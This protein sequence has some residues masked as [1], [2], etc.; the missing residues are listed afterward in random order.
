MLSHPRLISDSHPHLCA[1]LTFSRSQEPVT[2]LTRV[3]LCIATMIQSSTTSSEYD[4]M[5]CMS[6]I[7]MVRR[8]DRPRCVQ[9]LP[10]NT[11]LRLQRA[12][13]SSH[14]VRFHGGQY[15]EG[16]TAI[17]HVRRKGG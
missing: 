15:G 13:P 2:I 5:H 3:T 16:S 10:I 1:R 12:P 14:S 6:A 17:P 4:C 11:S 9:Q 7:I 8:K